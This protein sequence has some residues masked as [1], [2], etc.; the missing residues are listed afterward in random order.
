MVK[1]NLEGHAISQ[2]NDPMGVTVTFFGPAPE[3][4]LPSAQ[5]VETDAVRLVAAR[6][7][8]NHVSLEEKGAPQGD[9]CPNSHPE[10]PVIGRDFTL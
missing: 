9:I 8:G 10:Q 1:A 5:P 4:Q 7:A 3:G 6:R 2:R